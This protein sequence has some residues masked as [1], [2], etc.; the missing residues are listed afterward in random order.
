MKVT[1]FSPLLHQFSDEHS[2]D[3]LSHLQLC[4]PCIDKKGEKGKQTKMEK[5][6]AKLAFSL[7]R[8]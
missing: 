1:R 8:K 2:I 6:S 4:Q 3:L 7:L 5:T